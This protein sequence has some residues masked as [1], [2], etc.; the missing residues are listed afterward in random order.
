MKKVQINKKKKDKGSL[1]TDLVEIN[2][3]TP[4]Q[5][6][7][8]LISQLMKTRF[9]IEMLKGRFKNGFNL[10]MKFDVSVKVGTKI[11]DLTRDEIESG[12]TFRCNVTKNKFGDVVRTRQENFMINANRIAER[13]N[14][15]LSMG[16][17]IMPDV[18]TL[19]NK[20]FEVNVSNVKLIG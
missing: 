18:V 8:I 14:F 12:I 3:E 13:I 5:I 10:N 1:T 20:P 17:N 9:E 11:Y 4:S 19:D 2:N 6:S 7:E 15:T 16:L